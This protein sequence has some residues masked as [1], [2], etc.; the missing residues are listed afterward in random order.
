M[1]NFLDLCNERFA[2]RKFTDEPVSDEDLHY[3]MESIRLAPS[4]ANRQPWRFLI[5]R[6]EE[7]KRKL[8]ECY[9]GPWFQSAPIYIIGMKNESTCWVRKEDGKPHADIDLA[10]ATE[11][12]CLAAAERG[13][14]TCWVCHYDPVKLREHFP[15]EGFEAVVI[16][17]FG[18]LAADCPRKEKERKA[19]EEIFKE[20]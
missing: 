11:H 19:S 18:H 3:L 12:F 6:S 10:I 15:E 20:M 1:K 13:L 16:V 5:V 7:A 17:P 8:R 14:G 4:A 9:A 2:A